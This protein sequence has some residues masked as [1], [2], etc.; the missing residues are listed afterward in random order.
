MGNAVA[1][2]LPRWLA[3]RRT[4]PPP[5]RPVGSNI[6]PALPMLLALAVAGFV[7]Y[8]IRKRRGT[9]ANGRDDGHDR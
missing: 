8:L 9:S 1:P 4:Q 5:M 7:I 6:G 3:Q 2:S